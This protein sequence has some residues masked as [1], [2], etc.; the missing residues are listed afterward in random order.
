M[1]RAGLGPDEMGAGLPWI[2]GNGV[3]GRVVTVGD[4]VPE[5]RVG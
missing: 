2:P 5:A 4:R 3:A 1:L